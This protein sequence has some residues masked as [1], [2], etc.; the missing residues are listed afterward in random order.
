MG[1]PLG[2]LSGHPLGHPPPAEVEQQQAAEEAWLGWAPPGHWRGGTDVVLGDFM[3]RLGTR[4]NLLESELK[5]AWRALDLL[6]HEYIRMWTRLEKLEAL[7]YEQQNV[8]GQLLEFYSSVE[9]GETYS[10]NREDS[11][12]ISSLF[13]TVGDVKK[14]NTSN[15]SD[16][17]ISGQP[18]N[19]QIPPLTIPSANREF[20]A[21]RAL[22]K[23]RQRQSSNSVSEA[24]SE[25]S[26]EKTDEGPSP[27]TS[28]H[29]DNDIVPKIS[30]DDSALFEEKEKKII[31]EPTI[32]LPQPSLGPLPSIESS[33]APPTFE[34][35]MQAPGVFQAPSTLPAVVPS[36]TPSP[37]PESQEKP[38]GSPSPSMHRGQTGNRH[39]LPR[40]QQSLEIPTLG[41][42]G[43]SL[44]DD[45]NRSTHS[46]RSTSRVS[47]R[48][49]STED[50]IDSEDEW[51]WYELRKLEEMERQSQLD[52]TDR[53]E[54]LPILATQYEQ[55][56]EAKQQMSFVLQ[57]LR[58]KV[59]PTPSIE[60]TSQYAQEIQSE[61]EL[62]ISSTNEE[63]H[64]ALYPIREMSPSERPSEQPEEEHSSG[65]TSGPDSPQ[66]TDIEDDSDAAAAEE[67]IARSRQQHMQGSDSL[68]RE[69]SV[70]VGPSERSMSVQGDSE[71]TATLR[72][73]SRS[74]SVGQSDEGDRRGST[75]T[76]A[77]AGAKR[78][79]ESDSFSSSKEEGSKW[80]LLKALKER[81]AEEKTMQE[82]K[83]AAAAAGKEVWTVKS[84]PLWFKSVSIERN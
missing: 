32:I 36:P 78:F 57:E 28:R 5:Y 31:E 15:A 75:A 13:A 43:G 51:Y 8:I 71:E 66:Q 12:D 23:Y 17:E 37:Q 61:V 9:A 82:E 11:T 70:S 6:S 20:A 7:L 59:Q 48:R 34:A 56:D 41:R 30:E 22:G 3:Q 27:R 67:G 74:T 77:S 64:P 52:H 54:A 72:E 45:D 1:L 38:E 79:G 46:W 44:E 39:Y 65:E 18:E 69:G 84:A 10:R 25:G 68:S 26:D 35:R 58:L 53:D 80:K 55:E 40:H 19:I 33:E 14:T 16:S 29:V 2:P 81:K 63:P 21:S 42:G 60:E 73:G 76:T 49:Q 83:A 50:S 47:S 62:M 4:L 24:M